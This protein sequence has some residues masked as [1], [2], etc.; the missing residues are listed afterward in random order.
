[1]TKKLIYSDINPQ[2]DTDLE[3]YQ[4]HDN[5][6]TILP[7]YEMITAFRNRLVAQAPNGAVELNNLISIAQLL[8]ELYVKVGTKQLIKE[9]QLKY[10]VYELLK[11]NDYKY[12][13]HKSIDY[14]IQFMNQVDA[15]LVDLSEQEVSAPTAELIAIY[16]AIK[17]ELAEQGLVTKWQSYQELLNNIEQEDFAYLY[18]EIEEL[19]LYR[20]QIIKAVELE[21][22]LK[23]ADFVSD[24]TIVLDY[25]PE[26]QKLFHNLK[27]VVERLEA[28]DFDVEARLEEEKTLIQDLFN[29]QFKVDKYNWQQEMGT[30]LQVSSKA[31]VVEELKATARKIVSLAK[32]GQSLDRIGIAF[33]SPDRY[34]QHLARVFNS[35]NLPYQQ[36]IPH[37]LAESSLLQDIK[38]VLRLLQGDFT[39]ED[40]LVLLK[41]D[42]LELTPAAAADYHL[43][44]ILKEIRFPVEGWNL[45]DLILEQQELE[46]ELQTALE[47]LQEYCCWRPK[48]EVSSEE[49]T[50]R[51]KDLLTDLGLAQVLAEAPADITAAWQALQSQIAS[52]QDL[53]L[54]I[55]EVTEWVELVQLAIKEG[56]YTPDSNGGVEVTGKIEL[57]SGDYDY[58]FLLGMSEELYPTIRQNPIDKYL[59][60]VNIKVDNREVRDRYLLNDHLLSANKGIFMLYSKT[61]NQEEALSSACIEELSRVVELEEIPETD[62]IYSQQELQQV[63]GLDLQER[64]LNQVALDYDWG[65]GLEIKAKLTQGQVRDDLAGYNGNL[66]A[67]DNLNWLQN[68]YNDKYNYSA[69]FLEKYLECPFQFLLDKVFELE[70]IEYEEEM[71]PLERGSLLHRILDQFY[72]KFAANKV[73]EE[74]YQQAYET[75]VQV[76]KE[77]LNEYNLFEHSFYWATEG[78][79]Y[80][81]NDQL[82]IVLEEF[83]ENELNGT[84]N[85]YYSKSIPASEL[86]VKETEWEFK[87][88]NLVDD[89]LFAGKID[90]IDYHSGRDVMGVIDYKTGQLQYKKLS[91]APVQIPLY[92]MAVKQEFAHEVGMGGYFGLHPKEDRDSRY[93]ILLGNQLR[94]SYSGKLEEA[95]DKIREAVQG[96]KSGKFGPGENSN[97]EF[98]NYWALCQK[99]DN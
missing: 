90:R 48:E 84:Y 18:P 28:E 39:A 92:M 67:K 31:D 13:D 10:L 95:E 86:E 29:D 76:T 11:N 46:A 26:K 22:I 19:F 60:E 15:R 63:V 2:L 91:S 51:L 9:Q 56:T 47:Q 93:K 37:P 50:A 61:G 30:K 36:Q 80:L 98:C 5:A 25:D 82:G 8:Q 75:L 7:Y 1:M 14:I 83:L 69:S 57:R 68:K 85:Q 16:Q 20:L 73:T 21:L 96:I 40:L 88:L 54:G 49:F 64:K 27:D 45:V 74:N 66:Q 65:Q 94:K 44:Q 78:S 97:C 33:S 70:E 41:S 6:L 38:V 35:Y 58:I 23:L 42:W 43:E 17:E 53:E 24:T 34:L 99:E 87:N 81:D 12:F 52:L 4:E 3:Y 59:E 32:E 72:T 77:V 71:N 62:E 55:K 79:R 89:Y